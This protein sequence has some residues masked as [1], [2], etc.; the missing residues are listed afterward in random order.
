MH[1]F[2]PQRA[3]RLQSFL[4]KRLLSE[5]NSFMELDPSTLRYIVA[6]D[7]AY[8]TSS[9]CAVVVVYSLEKKAIVDRAHAIID[10]KAP[11]IPGLL[12][13]REVPGYMRAYRKLRV[14]PDLLLVDGHGLT[15]PRSFGI[16]TH[17]GV[18]LNKP[19]IG[20]AK[21]KLYGEL[22][23]IDNRVFIRSH[24]RLVGEVIRHRG[25][26]LYVS[27]G[28]KINLESAVKITTSLLDNK[29]RLPLPLEEAD[30]Y[31]KIVKTKY[32]K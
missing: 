3:A 13:F 4:A 6:F 21:S 17:L 12:A 22:V 30:K 29:H 10:I 28:Y 9:Q 2:D 15:H 25:Q 18:V 14:E 16:A 20:V 5:L 32:C 7:S 26:E 1:L 23:K 24:G 11:Y 31:S 27:I 8:T 19:S